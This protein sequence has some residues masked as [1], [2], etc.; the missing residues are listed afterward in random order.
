MQTRAAPA[1]I[2]VEYKLAQ[3]LRIGA[4]RVLGD[5]H[6]RQPFAHRE[7]DRLLGQP[8]QLIERPAFGVLPERARADERAALDRHADA[9]RDLGDRLDVGD[10]ASAPRSSPATRSR[11]S[12]DLARQPLD[13]RGPRAGPAP[14]RPMSAVS[15]PSAIDEVQDA[16]ASPRSSGTAPTATAARRAA[17]RRRAARCGGLCSAVAFQS[18]ISG[19]IA[20]RAR[21][22]RT[23]GA[24][25]AAVD[26]RARTRQR[27]SRRQQRRRVA[28]RR[29]EMTPERATSTR[30]DGGAMRPTSHRR[31]APGVDG[32]PA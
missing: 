31:A 7:G 20:R 32:A 8:Q 9:L 26:S 1:R 25:R 30:P 11:W 13:V 29:R 22:S 12:G 15:M 4:G 10:D 19:C 24:D 17:S 5:V 27:R 14:G 16:R 2:A 21:V 18:W 28:G 23:A 6:H 3:R